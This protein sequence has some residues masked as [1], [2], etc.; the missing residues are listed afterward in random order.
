MRNSGPHR[1]GD[2][3]AAASFSPK[4][5]KPEHFAVYTPGELRLASGDTIRITVNGRDKSGKHKLN[6]GAVYEV[7]GF[8]P[9]G[10]ITLSN[11]WVLDKDFRFFANGRVVT[12]HASQGAHRRPG[13]GRDGPRVGTCDLR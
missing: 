6:N 3:V 8:T 10:D 5:V 4:G 11:G 9:G 2:R 7:A 13:A 12:S 1:A